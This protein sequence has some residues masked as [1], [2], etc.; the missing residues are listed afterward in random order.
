MKV[1][2]TISRLNIKPG[3]LVTITSPNP[4]QDLRLFKLRVDGTI[5]GDI[6]YTVVNYELTVLVVR[7]IHDLDF[8]WQAH[9]WDS[10]SLWRLHTTDSLECL[11]AIPEITN[12]R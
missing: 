9:S 4:N 11:F 5:T 7:V 2:P 3:M 6:L 1:M 12:E 10:S 8:I